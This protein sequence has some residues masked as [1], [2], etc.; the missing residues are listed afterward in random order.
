MVDKISLREGEKNVTELYGE[1][2]SIFWNFIPYDDNG[3]HTITSVEILVC[4]ENIKII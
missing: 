2:P 4:S 1:I 3:I